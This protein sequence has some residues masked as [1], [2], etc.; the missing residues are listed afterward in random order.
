MSRSAHCRLMRFALG[1]RSSTGT[2]VQPKERDVGWLVYSMSV[3]ADGFIET[4]GHE[5]DWVIVDE[6]LRYEVAD[7]RS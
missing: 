4:P 7:G 5:L 6:A 1:D 3:S 2:D